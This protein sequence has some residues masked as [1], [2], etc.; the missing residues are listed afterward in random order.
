MGRFM[1]ILGVFNVKFYIF[2]FGSWV[3]GVSLEDI[4]PTTFRVGQMVHFL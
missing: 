1:D 4:S 3:A 2:K